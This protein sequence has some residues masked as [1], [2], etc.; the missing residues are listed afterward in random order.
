M[1]EKVIVPAE[2]QV[3]LAGANGNAVPLCD[4]AGNVIAYAL[5]PA[6]MEKIEEERKA[7]YDAASSIVTEEELDLAERAGGS[8]TMAEVFNRVRV[9]I[10]YDAYTMYSA[11]AAMC[12]CLSIVVPEEGV[13]K[14]KWLP[15]PADRYGMA[16]GFDDLLHA[17]Q[18]RQLVLPRLKAQ[19]QAAPG[20]VPSTPL[21]MRTIRAASPTAPVA[22]L[23]IIRGWA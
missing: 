6:R 23:R 7:M 2:M 15:N 18:T 19:E 8:H 4:E 3:K 5:S 12:G 16:Y 10:S 11:Y 1:S 17:E 9:C 20:R 22:R 13:S 21:I 14:E